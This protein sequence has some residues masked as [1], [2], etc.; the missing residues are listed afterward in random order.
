MTTAA[1]HYEMDPTKSICPVGLALREVLE[2]EEE[3]R[4]VDWSDSPIQRWLTGRKSKLPG[5]KLRRGN[6]EWRG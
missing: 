2:K 1:T 3:K 6:R 4:A 5:G